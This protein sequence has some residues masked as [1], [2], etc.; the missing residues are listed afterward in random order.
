MAEGKYAACAEVCPTGATLYGPV[1]ELKKEVAR[2]KALTPGTE[3]VFP[4]GQ[5]GSTDTF[6][7]PV[8][9]YIDHVWGEKEIGGTQVLHMSAVPFDKLDKKPLPDVAPAKVAETLNG[10]IYHGMIAPLAFLGVLVFAA[11]RSMKDVGEGEGHDDKKA[12]HD[13]KGE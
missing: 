4:R 2:R 6:V 10:R 3:A 9:T 5:I 13:R 8:A 7:A 12:A 1:N 11:K